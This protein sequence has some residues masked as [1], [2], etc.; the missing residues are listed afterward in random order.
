MAP[1]QKLNTIE[2]EAVMLL[3]VYELIDSM[4]NRALL[5]IFE[6]PIAEIRFKDWI[7]ARFFN[8]M[9]VDL[10]SP[11]D[12]DAP[13]SRKTYLESLNFICES[14][15]FDRNNSVGS[16]KQSVTNFRSWLNES[17]TIKKMW[18]PTISLEIDL[19]I[20]R[21]DLLKISGNI[22]K[23]NLLRSVQTMRSFQKVLAENEATIDDKSA[24]L[25]MDEVYE[26]FHTDK[27]M[28]QSNAI[29]EFL[30]NIR[31]G[32]FD[33]LIPEY[34]RSKVDEQN[35][36]GYSFTYPT[37]LE[38]KFARVSYWELMNKVRSGPYLPRLKV[39]EF[40]KGRVDNYR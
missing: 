6:G 31:W 1:Q 39:D 27:F 22:C 40:W 9:L 33:Y 14:P 13:V 29:V 10:L 2:T 23:H 32:I 34:Q 11:T 20:K 17:I 35:G 30:N 15:C 38:D 12:K 16:L 7:H 8:L 26:W 25:L 28:A 3:A 37:D 21:I 36:I 18:L 4:A 24:L 19:K 5:D